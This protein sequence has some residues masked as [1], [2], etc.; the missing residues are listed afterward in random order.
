M[1]LKKHCCAGNPS[2]SGQRLSL[3]DSLLSFFFSPPN[4]IHI[5]ILRLCEKLVIVP[6]YNIFA[7]FSI[8]YF[9]D[10]HKNEFLKCKLDILLG[11]Q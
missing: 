2:N 3:L 8:L 6:I 7:F 5:D 1:S 11:V 10:P 9:R 4:H